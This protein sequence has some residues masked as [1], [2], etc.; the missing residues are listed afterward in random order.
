MERVDLR[1]IREMP[2]RELQKTADDLESR[3]LALRYHMTQ[4]KIKNVHEF[5]MVSKD[6]AR[7]R[8]V[9]RERE[10]RSIKESL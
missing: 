4:G 9:L 3:R 5:R 7:V 1:H 8:T 2:L 6:L 10:I